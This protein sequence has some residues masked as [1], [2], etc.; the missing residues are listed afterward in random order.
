MSE[1]IKFDEGKLPW[2]LL[3]WQA[4]K[5]VVEVMQFGA[6]KYGSRNWENGMGHSRMFAATQRHLIAYWN[7]QD[8][9][10]ET[11]KLH[12]AHAACDIL[13]LLHW[14]LYNVP[15]DDRP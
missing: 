2:H 14:R 5:L 15:T 6:E 8:R 1:G 13:F 10:P 4:I 3:P 9:D 11:G 7:G 12:L